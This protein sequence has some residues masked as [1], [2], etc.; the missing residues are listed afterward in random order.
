MRDAWSAE[1]VL[2]GMR[3]EFSCW[4]RGRMRCLNLKEPLPKSFSRGFR[5]RPRAQVLGVISRAS[6]QFFEPIS[7][8]VFGTIPNER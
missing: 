1:V 2:F 3:P 7:F 8:S 6:T 5:R 4:T